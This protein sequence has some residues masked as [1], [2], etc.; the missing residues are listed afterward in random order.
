MKII[1]LGFVLISLSGCSNWAQVPHNPQY[2]ADDYR[3]EN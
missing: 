1:L 2:D 3:T